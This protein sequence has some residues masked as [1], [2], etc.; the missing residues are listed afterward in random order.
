[1]QNKSYRVGIYTRLSK[2]DGTDGESISIDTQKHFL[3]K[4]VKENNWQITEIYVDDG[5]SGTN[6][7]RPDFQRMIRDIENN[8][9]DCVI[10]KDLSRLGRN[11]L[12]CGYYLEVF[13]P[14]HNVRYI[15]L[16]DGVDTINNTSMDITPFRNLLNEMY[17]KDTSKK[18]KTA[19]RTRFE[20]G[21][22]MVTYAPYGY[23]KDPND[24]NHLIVDEEIRPIIKT[25]YDLCTE[26]GYGVRKI[27]QYLRKNKVI[28]PSAYLNKR[29][30][31]GFERYAKYEE[32][33]WSENGVRAILRSPV[34]AGNL[35]G[36]KRVKLS[37]K[38][39]KRV[40]RKPEEWKVVYNTHEGI[41][42]QEQWDLAQELMNKRRPEKTDSGYENIFAG[43][44]KCADCGYALCP[45]TAHRRKRP[46]V[47]D[48]IQYVCNNYDQYGV[49]NCTQHSIEA[50][51]LQELVLQDVNYFAE[52]AFTDDNMAELIQEKLKSESRS[53][54][55]ISRREENRL[56]KRLNELDNIFKKLYEDRVLDNITER[57]Y[58]IMSESYQKE[59]NEIV[60][61][62]NK[63]KLAQKE[64]EIINNNAIEFVDI[65]KEYKGIE[66]LTRPIVVKL[67]DKIAITEK[68][69]GKD[70]IRNQDVIIYYKLVGNLQPLSYKVPKKRPVFLGA[71]PKRKCC[72]CGKEYQPTSN[73]QKYC[74]K[75]RKIVRRRQG[76]ESKR[77]SREK[78]REEK[79]LKSGKKIA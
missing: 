6:F 57:N 37:M 12:Q 44:I 21:K 79:K 9:L 34:Y 65:I 58:N 33:S 1:M 10:T 73:V 8:K 68:Y 19:I 64:E 60:E 11:Y 51:T 62:L 24:H 42:S 14:E 13:F 67:I 22:C 31:K 4:Y 77:K 56:N 54:E 32:Y 29:G 40:S 72:E 55:K 18:I 63:I 75:C 23:L 20:N 43:I 69:N 46:Q 61:K 15:A 50:R 52:K 3:T 76:N 47:I 66:K 71:L 49:K 36:Y 2:D 38:S 5:Y 70:G 39:K 35:V 41:V 74:S 28:R 48:C 30:I 53:N 78:A 16:S 7:E 26:K 59:Q 17:V 25:I 27:M 45:T